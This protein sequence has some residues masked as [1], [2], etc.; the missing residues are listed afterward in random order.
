MNTS[1]EQLFDA[2]LALPDGDRVELAEALLASLQPDDRPPFDE[3]WR[4]VIQRRSLELRSGLVAGIP[5][6]EVKRQAREK[7]GG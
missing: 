6:A 2:A 4:E 3:S 1:T 7:A 5:W